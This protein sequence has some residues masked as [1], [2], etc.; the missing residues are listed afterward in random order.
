MPC[1]LTL[2]LSQ[3]ATVYNLMS[4]SKTLLDPPQSPFKRGIAAL[5]PSFLR[6]VREDQT[7]RMPI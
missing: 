2:T 6:R 5:V 7:R 4:D 1:A 3:K